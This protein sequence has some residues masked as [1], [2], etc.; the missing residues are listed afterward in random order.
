MWDTRRRVWARAAKFQRAGTWLAVSWTL[1]GLLLIVLFLVLQRLEDSEWVASVNGVKIRKQAYFDALVEHAGPAVL[2][3]LILE[4]LIRQEAKRKGVVVTQEEVKRYLDK[5][6]DEFGSEEAFH[7]NIR[8]DGF[9]ERSLRREIENQIYIRKLLEPR[10]QL[11]EKTVLAEY[12]IHKDHKG[13]APKTKEE[14][15]AEV[16]EVLLTEEIVK[17]SEAWFE[18]LR[19]RANIVISE[20]YHSHLKEVMNQR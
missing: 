8:R 14:K 1:S 15:L 10:V 13:D 9:T 12:E 11:D 5:M 2:D 7:E 3:K 16:R 20:K 17:L 19:S 6:S 18:E 4:E